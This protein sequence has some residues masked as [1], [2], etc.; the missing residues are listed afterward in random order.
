MSGFDYYDPARQNLI[1]EHDCVFEDGEWWF[2]HGMPCKHPQLHVDAPTW[3]YGVRLH[4]DIRYK[5]DENRTTYTPP[6]TPH[7]SLEWAQEMAALNP[8][9][10]PTFHR[11]RKAGAW[12]TVSDPQ[13]RSGE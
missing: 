12:E 7:P 1:S 2:G 8:L 6:T 9:Y 11:R 4:P 10:R 5:P 3:E 13:C